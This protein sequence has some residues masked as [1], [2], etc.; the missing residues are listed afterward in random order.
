MR[1]KRA[2]R[3]AEA[4]HD[5]DERHHD[6]GRARE[7]QR[8]PAEPGEEGAHEQQ[9]APRAEQ[10]L[11]AAGALEHDDLLIIPPLPDDVS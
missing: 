4:G 7:A 11:E 10:Q 6:G 1:A 5:D 2:A 8:E 9:R 3:E